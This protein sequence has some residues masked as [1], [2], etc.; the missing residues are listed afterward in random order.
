MSADPSQPPKVFF[1]EEVRDSSACTTA[2]NLKIM[3]PATSD[4]STESVD[5][6]AAT[7]TRDTQDLNRSS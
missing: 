1:I 4:V 2:S 6:Q 7:V 3:A 5:R